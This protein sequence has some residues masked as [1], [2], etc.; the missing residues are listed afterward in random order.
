MSTKTNKLL[1]GL[2]LISLASASL[3]FGSPGG[4]MKS[5]QHRGFSP[6]G[7]GYRIVNE[8]NLTTEQQNQM[9]TIMQEQREAAKAWRKKQ[10]EETEA[11]LSKVLNPEQLE[12][13]KE[14]KQ[15]QRF[16][17]KRGGFKHSL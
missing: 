7:G 10:A 3:A 11:K 12:Q 6:D 17:G 9:Q 4:G 5:C 14:F 8:L 16:H 13:F 2:A 15:H 1:I